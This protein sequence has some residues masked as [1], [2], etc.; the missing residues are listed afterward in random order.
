MHSAYHKTE[1]RYIINQEVG[2]CVVQ[3][4]NSAVNLRN[5]RT[6]SEFACSCF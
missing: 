6:L 4:P 5:L 3:S 1:I 2:K